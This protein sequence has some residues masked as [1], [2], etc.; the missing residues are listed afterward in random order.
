MA[1]ERHWMRTNVDRL[2]NDK[3]LKFDVTLNPY[4]FDAVPFEEA[5][6]NV[7]KLIAEKNKPIY[8]GLSGGMDSEYVAKSFIRCGIDFVPVLVL[9]EGNT[10]EAQYA[11][12]FCKQHNLALKIID[13]N[14]KQLFELYYN[15]IFRR[16]GGNGINSTRGILAANYAKQ[17]GGIFV[18][19]EHIL[20]EGALGV[21]D[22]DFYNDSIFDQ[23][24]IQYFFLY[25]PQ[26]VYSILKAYDH[27][28][29][30][31]F[32]FNLYQIPFR[33]KIRP[34]LQEHEK[35]LYRKF[36]GGIRRKFIFPET[37]LDRYVK[38]A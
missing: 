5:S 3:M 16:L 1:T 19:S 23:E 2:K 12:H 35:K 37:S 20:D 26:I 21:Y 34:T 8:I 32:K 15:L 9:N 22:W 11:I 33:P 31:E 7:V 17:N 4:E 28:D 13:T 36:S 18:L 6:F 25:T 24:L 29:M 10:L 27:T 14:E 30:Q 38:V